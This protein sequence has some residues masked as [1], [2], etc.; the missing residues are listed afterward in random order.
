[1][2][3]LEK[4]H[5]QHKYG[6]NDSNFYIALIVSRISTILFGILDFASLKTRNREFIITKQVVKKK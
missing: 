4:H 2:N 5:Q 3:G 1:M 6:N